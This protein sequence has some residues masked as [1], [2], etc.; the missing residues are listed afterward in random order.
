[1]DEISRPDPG[2]ACAY[3]AAMVDIIAF[4]SEVDT[5]LA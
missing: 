3:G 1:M 2:L 5:R 4:S